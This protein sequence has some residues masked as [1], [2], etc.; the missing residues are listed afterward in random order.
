MCNHST[1]DFPLTHLTALKAHLRLK[2]WYDFPAVVLH[3]EESSVKRHNLYAA[4][5]SGDAGAAEELVLQLISF[6]ACE[7]ISA[8]VGRRRPALLAV[9]A[10]ES[11]GVNVIPMA[12]AAALSELLAWPLAAGIVQINRVSHTGAGGYFRLAF[13]TLFDGGVAATDYFLVDDFIGQG[14]TLANLKGYL[15]SCG[16]RV[17]GVTALTGKT[18]SAKLQLED[19]TWQELRRKHGDELEQW[20]CTAFGY[21][22][23]CLT[24]SEARYLIRADDAHAIRTRIVAAICA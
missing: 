1:S 13:P 5:K 7:Q 11:Q 16:A 8:T 12:L 22:F 10:R 23:E 21:G 6:T 20:W 2:P 9:H 3:A 17:C 15:E 18:Y 24:E 19:G 14:G 4:A